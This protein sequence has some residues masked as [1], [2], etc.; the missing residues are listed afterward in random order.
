[1]TEKYLLYLIFYIANNEIRHVIKQNGK[2]KKYYVILNF[3]TQNFL[4]FATLYVFIY[5]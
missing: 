5:T 1:M 4:L 3:P 2:I